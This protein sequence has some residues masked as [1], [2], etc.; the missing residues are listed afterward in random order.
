MNIKTILVLCLSFNAIVQLKSF[1]E[2]H[3]HTDEEIRFILEGSG[4]FDVRDRQDRWL[5]IEVLKG[6][7]IVLPAGIYHR[8][9]LDTNV[10]YKYLVM[11]ANADCESRFFH[12]PR[13][14]SRL[15]VCSKVNLS[16]LQLTGQLMTT[17]CAVTISSP[18]RLKT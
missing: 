15:C 11:S 8:F 4:Y 9:T 18:F 17:Q 16:G 5:R 6:D 3:L 12:L 1:F 7:L 14:I 13:T 2:E 10:C